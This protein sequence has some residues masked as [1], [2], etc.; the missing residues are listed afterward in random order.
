MTVIL[1]RME[2]CLPCVIVICV[3]TGWPFVV[4]LFSLKRHARFAD[5]PDRIRHL[6]TLHVGQ[7]LMKDRHESALTLIPVEYRDSAEKRSYVYI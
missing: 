1:C 4:S 2:G 6:E 7:M 3:H 5:L